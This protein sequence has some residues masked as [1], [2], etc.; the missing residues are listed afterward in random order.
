MSAKT[1]SG[2]DCGSDH[3]FLITEFRL[4]LTKVWKT[5]RQSGMT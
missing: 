4:K 5:T 2:V 3:E 1:R